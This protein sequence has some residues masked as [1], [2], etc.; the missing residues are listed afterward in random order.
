MTDRKNKML[1]LSK[2]ETEQM[3][4]LLLNPCKSLIL[5]CLHISYFVLQII[6]KKPSQSKPHQLVIW[7][8]LQG[9]RYI[10][11]NKKMGWLNILTNLLKTIQENMLY[12]YQKWLKYQSLL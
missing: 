2:T 10:M 9:Q 12:V 7:I 3:D 4:N 1:S 8:H 6:A 5:T 11:C